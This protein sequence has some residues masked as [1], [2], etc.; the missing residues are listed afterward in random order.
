MLEAAFTRAVGRGDA[1]LR[2]LV[3]GEN[4]FEGE[5]TYLGFRDRETQPPPDAADV[6]AAL[7][8]RRLVLDGAEGWRLR[9]PLADESL[10]S[11]TS[12][13]VRYS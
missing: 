1:V 11:L 10:M 13:V 4:R 9:A 5:R 7:R 8:R 3:E 6:R 12:Q 2:Q